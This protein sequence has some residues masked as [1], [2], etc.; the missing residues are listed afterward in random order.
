MNTFKDIPKIYEEYKNKCQ[1]LFCSIPLSQYKD[2]M[3]TDVYSC[4][5]CT[6]KVMYCDDFAYIYNAESA[7]VISKKFEPDKSIGAIS[8]FANNK[9]QTIK[10]D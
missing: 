9:N 6:F 8:L 4:D 10:I 1:C 2:V 5:S 3:G 7:I